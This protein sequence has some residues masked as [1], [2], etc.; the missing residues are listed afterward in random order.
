MA[1]RVASVNPL[2]AMPDL[3]EIQR[4]D[5][6]EGVARPGGRCSLAPDRLTGLVEEFKKRLRFTTYGQRLEKAIP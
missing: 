2:T 1:R 3:L 4:N 5:G 6:G